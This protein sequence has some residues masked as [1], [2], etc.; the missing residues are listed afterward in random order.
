VADVAAKFV[1]IRTASF[2]GLSDR[3]DTILGQCDKQ[4]KDK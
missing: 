4:M 1:S 3:T 2:Q